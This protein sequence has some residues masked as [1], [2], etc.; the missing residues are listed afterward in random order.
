MDILALFLGAV[1][2]NYFLYRHIPKRPRI[3]PQRFIRTPPTEKVYSGDLLETLKK[4]SRDVTYT[5]LRIDVGMCAGS[6]INLN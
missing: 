5:Y 4:S 3:V 1:I 6:E 2:L